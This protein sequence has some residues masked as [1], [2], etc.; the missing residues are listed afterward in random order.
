M[1]PLYGNSRIDIAADQGA[2]YSSD[3][4]FLRKDF[5]AFPAAA[6]KPRLF[7]LARATCITQAS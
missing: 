5:F 7:Q 2:A 1:L 4:N 3:K 6:G